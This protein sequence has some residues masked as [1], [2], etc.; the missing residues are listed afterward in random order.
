[1]KSWQDVARYLALVKVVLKSKVPSLPAKQ[2]LG[3]STVFQK[4]TLM[5]KLKSQEK[6]SSQ[7][8]HLVIRAW[9][10]K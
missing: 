5:L 6:F 4:D 7:E 2:G 3:L 9:P 1:M 10:K 8:V